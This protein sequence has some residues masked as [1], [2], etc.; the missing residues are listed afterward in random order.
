MKSEIV[1]PG[2]YETLAPSTPFTIAGAAW[3]GETEVTEV[4]VSTDGGQTWARAEFIDPAHVMP[5]DAGNSTG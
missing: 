3:S 1:R 2:V 5:G 4:N